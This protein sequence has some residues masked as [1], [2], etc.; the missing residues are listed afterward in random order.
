MMEL[1]FKYLPFLEEIINEPVYIVIWTTFGLPLLMVTLYQLS[2][3]YRKSF[4]AKRLNTIIF[5]SLGILWITG[6]ILM[7]VLLSLKIS[8]IK[9]YFIWILLV[10]SSFIFTIFNSNSISKKFDE[11][12]KK[13]SIKERR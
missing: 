2:K 10:I 9:M 8:G 4:F 3:L 13:K 5:T 12:I 6:F 11:L 1:P 7:L